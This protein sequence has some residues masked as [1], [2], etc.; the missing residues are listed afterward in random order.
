M[1]IE[2][3]AIL[4]FKEYVTASVTAFLPLFGVITGVFVAFAIANMARFLIMKMIKK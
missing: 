1:T 3:D 4:R 2:A